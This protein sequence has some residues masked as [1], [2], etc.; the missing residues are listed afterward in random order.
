MDAQ[1]TL[2][3]MLKSLLRLLHPFVPFVTET[4]WQNLEEKKPLIV[5]DWTK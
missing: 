1:Y 4:I 5:S 2:D 3:F